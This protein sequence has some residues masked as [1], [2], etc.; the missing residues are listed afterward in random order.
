MEEEYKSRWNSGEAYAK[1]LTD[2]GNLIDYYIQ[3]GDKQYALITLD[4]YY[5]ALY[6]N[7]K[8]IEIK[9]AIRLMKISHK[10]TVGISCARD[11]YFNNSK[12]IDFRDI[13]ETRRY[14]LRIQFERGLLNPIKVADKDIFDGETFAKETE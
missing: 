3:I 11:I 1:K 5:D 10:N 8:E 7:M 6:P 9:E 4:A 12:Q 2:L 14:L 13:R